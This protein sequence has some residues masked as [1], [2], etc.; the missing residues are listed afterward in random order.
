LSLFVYAAPVKPLAGEPLRVSGV[1]LTVLLPSMSCRR[2]WPVSLMIR[3]R[4]A[5]GL[6]STPKLTPSSGTE[7]HPTFVMCIRPSEPGAFGIV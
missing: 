1:S 2:F 4:S 6:T 7:S 3:S 5:A